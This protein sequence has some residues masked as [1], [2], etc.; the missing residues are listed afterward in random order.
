MSLRLTDKNFET[1]VVNSQLPVFVDFWGSWCPPCKMVEPIIEQLAEE[2]DGRIKVAKLN[3]DQNPGVR[4]KFGIAGAPRFGVFNKGKCL[5]KAI[6]AHS[7]NQLIKFID[8]ALEQTPAMPAQP[9]KSV[10][11]QKTASKENVGANP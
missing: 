5:K 3:V 11:A 1:E 2:L 7:K 4:A 10:P 6:G 8:S 9:I